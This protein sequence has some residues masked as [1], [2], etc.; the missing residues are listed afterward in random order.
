MFTSPQSYVLHINFLQR[1]LPFSVFLIRYAFLQEFF[2]RA[3]WC[4][5]SLQLVC[6]TWKTARLGS[7]GCLRAEVVFYNLFLC[8]LSYKSVGT[9]WTLCRHRLPSPSIRRRHSYLA[10]TYMTFF[11]LQ[12]ERYSVSR[13]VERN[14]STHQSRVNSP[15]RSWRWNTTHVLSW[16][17]QHTIEA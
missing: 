13:L 16:K 14:S 3:Y 6:K 7:C 4:L 2:F 5:K 17:A 8:L 12:R 15:R 9:I 10:C 1:L 11:G